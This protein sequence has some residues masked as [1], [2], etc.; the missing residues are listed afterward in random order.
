[1]AVRVWREWLAA[2]LVLALVA[3]SGK[4]GQHDADV[5]DG[6]GASS[7]SKAGAAGKPVH[8]TQ[9]EG[10]STQSGGDP[11]VGGEPGEVPGGGRAPDNSSGAPATA[12]AGGAAE[13]A[14]IVVGASGDHLVHESYGT[15][16]V[17]VMLT[18]PPS[19]NVV[20]GLASAD[21][22]HAVVS[23]LSLTFTPDNW[24]TAQTAIVRGVRDTI[25]D[26]GHTVTI[27]TLPALS[28]DPNY[29]GID[30]ANV[31][32]FVID[33]TNPGIVVGPVAGGSTSESGGIAT[34][35]IVLTS[36][37][38]STVTVPLSSSDPSEGSVVASVVFE[39]IDWSTPHQ[40]TVTG[41]DDQLADGQQ[42]YDIVTGAAI[43]DD[44][45]Y[46]G[47]DPSDVPLSNVDNE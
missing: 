30:A 5:P 47:I 10:G 25:A 45:H 11:I 26:D 1:M 3:C 37:P 12:G 40:V 31:D 18:A 14:G 33:E 8:P 4:S 32:V 23:P 20:I 13:E 21:T 24:S 35:N 42:I 17:Q 36:Q 2:S 39:P 27:V 19:A 38:T 41:V 22:V 7:S 44:V 43:S 34:F 28:A 15:V 6:T 9:S 46:A 29:N 16:Q